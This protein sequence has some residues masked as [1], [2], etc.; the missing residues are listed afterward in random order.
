MTAR[1][2]CIRPVGWTWWGRHSAR[3]VGQAKKEGIRQTAR[4]FTEEEWAEILVARCPEL[5]TAADSGNNE[6]IGN[7]ETV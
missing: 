3:V 4:K 5:N 7:K 1:M 6:V 2:H